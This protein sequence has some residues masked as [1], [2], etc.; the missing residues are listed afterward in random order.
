[1]QIIKAI[2]LYGLMVIGAFG[3]P[4]LGSKSTYEAVGQQLRMSESGLSPANGLD[5]RAL[6]PPSRKTYVDLG[7]AKREMSGETLFTDGLSTCIAI[8]VRSA[9]AVPKGKHDKIL[10]HVASTM[11]T[12]GE[13]PLLDDQLKNLFKLDDTTNIPNRQVFVL[14]NRDNNK[15][16]QDVFNNYVVQKVH[17][18]WKGI[19][20]VM[21]RD[22]K[23]EWNAQLGA[24]LWINDKKEVFWSMFD[25]PV[26]PAPA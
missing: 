11:C 20:T 8:V 18:H 19:E 21:Y 25:K 2:L 3:N 4:I 14:L 26:I 10:A 22:P 7:E 12:G 1:M 24:R 5:A 13:N 9:D 16:G 15:P 17:E 6:Y 23:Y